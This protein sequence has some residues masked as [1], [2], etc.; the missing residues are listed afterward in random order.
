ME[1]NRQ[2]VFESDLEESREKEV[3]LRS[4]DILKVFQVVKD[5]R[6]VRIAGAV[7]RDGEFGFTPGMTVKDLVS[8]SGGTKYFAY[9]KE[10]EL[11]RQHLSE[12]GPKV[13]KINIDLEKALAGDPRS[14][15]PL[16]EN[17]QIF[18]RTH[19]G[20]D[21]VH[22]GHDPRAKSASPGSTP[23]GRGSGCPP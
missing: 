5:R 11:S 8:L 12:T 6:T 16:Q 9:L 13:E 15:L 14:N 17:D 18:V 4:G 20:M 23:R 22:P 21:V 10:A 2:I 3:D 7:H 1:N 19:P